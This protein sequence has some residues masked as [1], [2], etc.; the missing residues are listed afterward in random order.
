MTRSRLT[1]NPAYSGLIRAL[2]D[3]FLQK[4][5]DQGVPAWLEATN[6]HSRDVY[7]HLGFRE[8]DQIRIGAGQADQTGNLI[9]GGEG[10][11]IFCMIAEPNI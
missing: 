1:R 11:T 7:E 3:P 6:K 10:I 9:A 8:V 5:A 2:I 4:A